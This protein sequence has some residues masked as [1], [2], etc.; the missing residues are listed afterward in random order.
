M[1]VLARAANALA[2]LQPESGEWSEC[3]FHQPVSDF[4][5]FGKFL[6]VPV[7]PTS[8][9]K[10]ASPTTI[11]SVSQGIACLDCIARAVGMDKLEKF[12]AKYLAGARARAAKGHDYIKATWPKTTQRPVPL[13][14]EVCNLLLA[15]ARPLQLHVA[16]TSSESLDVQL[17]RLLILSGDADGG[18][19]SKFRRAYIPSSSRARLE[20]LKDLPGRA[21]KAWRLDLP[22]ELNKAHV[23]LWNVTPNEFNVSPAVAF[24]TATAVH[25]LA[26]QVSNPAATL[27]QLCADPALAE[28]RK[29]LDALL[30][31]PIPPK[32]VPVV[33]AK[34]AAPKKAEQKPVAK[35][36]ENVPAIT[37]KPADTTKK[38]DE[39]F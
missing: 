5:G 20:V 1:A 24:A 28:Q 34:P 30:L 11:V 36:E 23:T 3:N 35:A 10:L 25:Y 29:G 37:I 21:W 17:T 13:K 22:I 31:T 33:A 39:S 2:T 7:D 12:Q 15:A 6:P 8:F 14:P 9:P 27:Q 19:G 4:D 16:E 18:W 38:K 26:S 32:P